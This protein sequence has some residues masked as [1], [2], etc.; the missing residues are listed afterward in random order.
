METTMAAN[1]VKSVSLTVLRPRLVKP[2]P[3]AWRNVLI[4]ASCHA[5]ARGLM[6]KRFLKNVQAFGK[7]RRGNFAIV[8]VLLS[9]PLLL[10]A[11]LSIDV[12][13]MFSVHNKLAFA[14]DAAAL[15]TTQDLT[16]GT[17]SED[18][19]EETVRKYLDAN[20]DQRNI[21]A[22]EVTVDDIHI[23]KV[24]RSVSI[25]AHAMMPMTFAGIVGYDKHRVAA[26]TK[27]QFSNTEVEVVMALDLTG[28]MDSNISGWGSPT[29]LSA[30]KSSA[31]LAVK[32]LFED[33]SEADRIRVGLVPYS[34]AVNAA[35][36]ID[37]IE[38]T[39]VTVCQRYRWNGSC[40]KWKTVY[41]DCVAER[42]GS[43]KYTDAFATS[44]AKITSSE[45]D[46]PSAEIV[47]MTT[48]ESK[49][50]NEI[51]NFR[52]DGCTAGHIAIAWSYYMLSSK[53]AAAWP[54]GSDPEPF[55]EAGVSKYAIIMT[56]GEFNT[57]ETGGYSCSS[58]YGAKQSETY[59]ENLCSAMKT[60]GIKIYS[61][62]FAAGSSAETLM[63]NC[64]SASAGK[65]LYYNA[66]DEDDLEAAFLEIARDIKGLRLVN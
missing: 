3:V 31:K 32:T 12:A 45:Y 5:K 61:I 26:E 14:V 4:R 18:D 34:E 57:F 17:I 11:S 50:K 56:D 51:N 55:G 65:K 62:A 23:D 1:P 25:E 54:A 42:T 43:Q 66:T 40:R 28:S 58:Y 19:A 9:V 33:V 27:A 39:G 30:L 44:A 20:L 41:P 64:A 59:A 16:L 49:L 63:R 48:D 21:L 15:A 24:N 7:D 46:C 29:K 37:S 38:T 53:W 8:F 6:M 47:P 22:S 13:R 2:N 35:P 36:V 52:A 60:S 10:A